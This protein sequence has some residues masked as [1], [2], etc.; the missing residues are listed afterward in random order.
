MYKIKEKKER[1]AKQN[2]ERN[3]KLLNIPVI[4]PYCAVHTSLYQILPQHFKTKRCKKMQL[5]FFEA[6]AK[7]PNGKN[8]FDIIYSIK[9]KI[10]QVL[11][12]DRYDKEENEVETKEDKKEDH[13]KKIDD[14]NELYKYY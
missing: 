8:E 10:E 12:G 7:K 4:C 6:E 14:I 9:G 3:D 1:L 2:K 5:L 13:N 11:K